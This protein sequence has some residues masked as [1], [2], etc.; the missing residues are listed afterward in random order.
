[1]IFGFQVVAQQLPVLMVLT[2]KKSKQLLFHPPSK[3]V[4]FSFPIFNW[5]KCTEYVF[6]PSVEFQAFQPI[7]EEQLY[8]QQAFIE[9]ET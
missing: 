6:L 8:A 2:F 3:F 4:H 1:V 9:F 5:I 7:S